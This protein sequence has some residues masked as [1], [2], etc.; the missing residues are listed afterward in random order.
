MGAL[1]NEV[2]FSFSQDLG[3]II[4]SLRGEKEKWIYLNPGLLPLAI[5]THVGG[6]TRGQQ[7]QFSPLEKE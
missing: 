5:F 2:F 3:N 1:P 7:D 4:M 6:Q